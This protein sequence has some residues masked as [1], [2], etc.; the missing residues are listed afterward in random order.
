M[1][2]GASA[3]LPAPLVLHLKQLFSVADADKSGELDWEEFWKLISDLQLRLSDEEIGE[4]QQYTD[5][6]ASGSV[7][8]SEFEP[9]AAELI[10]KY[11]STHEFED[12]WREHTDTE[13][14]VYRVNLSDGK[15]EWIK[16]AEKPMSPHIKHMWLLFKKHDSD[17]SGELDWPEFWSVLTE[18]GLE[19]TDDEIG[20]WQSYADADGNG[21]I[22][23]SEFEPMAEEIIAKFYEGHEWSG[24]EEDVWKLQTDPEG[25]S[26]MLNQNTGEWRDVE[27]TAVAAEP[28]EAPAEDGALAADAVEA[29]T[30][31]EAS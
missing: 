22:I 9:V 20:K 31:E 26:Y 3:A 21:S 6:D 25:Y 30:A 2:A 10:A 28:G 8:W 5:A 1:G 11:Y 27:S 17:D 12:Q 18:L 15:S 4:W 19:M 29:A 24:I 16:R 7:K 14:N 13:G 23:W